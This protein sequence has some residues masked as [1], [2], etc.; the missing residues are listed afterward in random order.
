MDVSLD[1]RPVP[2]YVDLDSILDSTPPVTTINT[3]NVMAIEGVFEAIFTFTSNEP[4]SSWECQLDLEPWEQC[5]SPMEYSDFA[6]G[7][8]VFRVRAIDLAL[9][10]EHPPVE[11]AFS[12]GVDATPP[13]TTLLETPPLVTRRRLRNVPLLVQRDRRDVRVRH[14]DRARRRPGLGRVLLAG[15]VRR[16]R[17]RPA[18]LLR[19]RRRPRRLTPD[20][21][22]EVYTWTYEPALATPDTIIHTKPTNPSTSIT[23]VFTFGSVGPAIEFEC[24]FDAEPFESCESPYLI[25]ELVPG[26]H[27][28]QVRAV[29]EFANVDETAA[30]YEWR[31]VAPPLEPTIE[32]TPPEPS[33]GNTHTFTFSSTEQN[34]TFECRITPNPFLQNQFE[35]CSSPH[36]YTGLPDG[37]YLFQVRA[38]NEY[39][40]AGE[41]PAEWSFDGRQP[42]RH[43]DRRRAACHD[44]RTE[45]RDRVRLQRAV[46]RGYVRVLPR[47]HRPGRVPLA[48]HD[49][50]PC[51][52]RS[53]RLS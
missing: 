33:I 53:A 36:T 43:G 31:S 52:D 12:V 6:P 7:N 3:A 37:E 27:V 18:H 22:P 15:P 9:N 48:V 28:F 13:E 47:R 26:M 49:P 51:R 39:G 40:I 41:I 1:R 8:H 45:H 10:V 46:G 35:A 19:A 25:E 42:A 50:G 20:P 32:S 44:I 5:E 30:V 14:R 38:V 34:A 29:D 17:A 2:G 11:H 16:A 4:V 23:A 21:S 24:A